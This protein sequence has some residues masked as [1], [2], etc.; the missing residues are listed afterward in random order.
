[1]AVSE[2][3]VEF[4]SFPVIHKMK[5]PAKVRKTLQKHYK[6]AAR[7]VGLAVAA[8]MRKKIRGGVGPPNAPMTKEIKGSTKQLVDTGRLFKAVTFK[9]E[10]YYSERIHVGVMR[11]NAA[12]NIARIVH[13]GANVT[14]TKRMSI[15]FKV[16]NS[17]T[18]GKPATLKGER[19][20]QLASSA[21]G[22]IP[23]LREGT[24]L[25]I[26]PRP[27]A[28]ETMADPKVKMIVQNEFR[29]AL[30]NTFKELSK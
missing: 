7:R 28:A 1:M 22:I 25:V 24:V 11:T 20:E 29:R 9:V 14:V 12:A 27:F 5:N 19:A 15:L 16:L 3:K 6:M 13:E 21:K 8:I 26:P 30:G 10:G 17:Y 18:R 4:S 2:V 23:A